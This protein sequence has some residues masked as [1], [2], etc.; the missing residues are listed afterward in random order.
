MN[1][2]LRG[3]GFFTCFISTTSSNPNISDLR[4]CDHDPF[5]VK[6]LQ[7]QGQ[8]WCCSMEDVKKETF[9][10]W[11]L[12]SLLLWAWWCI[13][14]VWNVCGSWWCGM[15]HVLV[16]VFPPLYRSLSKRV[17]VGRVRQHHSAH[18]LVLKK[19]SHLHTQGGK[20]IKV[21]WAVWTYARLIWLNFRNNT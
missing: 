17:P 19:T 16:T 7:R 8:I 5:I 21:R 6:T 14:L 9:L 13:I 1:T 15:C 11:L 4:W 18:T 10:D 12:L 2:W 20:K 3:W